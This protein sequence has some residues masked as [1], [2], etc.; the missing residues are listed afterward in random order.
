[1][2]IRDSFHTVIEL[3][4]CRDSAQETGSVGSIVAKI[5]RFSLCRTISAE[6]NDRS[7]PQAFWVVFRGP[8]Q[9]SDRSCKGLCEGWWIVLR[10]HVYNSHGGRGIGLIFCRAVCQ[11]G[12]AQT[13]VSDDKE[14][15]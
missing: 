2:W 14:A 5:E 15:C 10:S 12:R 7:G 1:M 3:G 6:T 4:S 9:S 13:P 8:E 11:L